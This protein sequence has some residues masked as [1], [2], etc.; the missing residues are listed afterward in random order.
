MRVTLPVGL[1]E[2]V[3]HISTCWDRQRIAIAPHDSPPSTLTAPRRARKM[4]VALRRPTLLVHE[5]FAVS[6]SKSQ[7]DQSGD[8]RANRV[9]APREPQHRT[10]RRT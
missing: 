1:A 5:G 7:C 10:V 3:I 8:T 9:I 6:W 4:L 2:S